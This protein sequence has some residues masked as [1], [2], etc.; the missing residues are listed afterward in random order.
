VGP[1]IWP[2]TDLA[3]HPKF[4]RLRYGSVSC[5]VQM[6]IVSTGGTGRLSGR[7]LMAACPRARTAVATVVLVML[8]LVMAGLATV[9]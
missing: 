7:L 3:R 4:A 9:P 2:A 6:P 1:T 8:V 5:Q